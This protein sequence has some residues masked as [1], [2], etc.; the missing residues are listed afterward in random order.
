MLTILLPPPPPRFLD[1]ASEKRLRLFFSFLSNNEDCND[2]NSN[3]HRSTFIR[4]GI[5]PRQIFALDH[6][7]FLCQEFIFIFY[8][9]FYNVTKN[10]V[11][12]LKKRISW[13]KNFLKLTAN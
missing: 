12:L 1:G 8:S 2:V 7:G 3:A 4:E 5:P 10:S 9:S 13:S 11:H 6:C